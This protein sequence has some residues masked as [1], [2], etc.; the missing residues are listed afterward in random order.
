MGVEVERK[1]LVKRELLSLPLQGQEMKQGYISG[2]NN[3]TVRIRIAG[4]KAFLTLKGKTV[5]ISRSEFEYEIPKSDADQMLDEFCDG[6]VV[7]KIRYEVTFGNHLWEVDVFEGENSGLIIA[8]IELSHSEESFEK[9]QW[10]EKEVS[11]DKQY[12]NSYLL[13]IPYN[14]WDSL[15]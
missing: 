6:K 7:K 9:P 15:E 12:F 5:G 4:E 1:F 8:E 3:T 14:S 2:G 11:G 10:L 13:D